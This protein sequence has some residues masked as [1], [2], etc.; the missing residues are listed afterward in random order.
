MVDQKN[1][2][3][4]KRSKKNVIKINILNMLLVIIAVLND[5]DNLLCLS[6]YPLIRIKKRSGKKSK[7]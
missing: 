3:Y 5:N 7:E 2:Y 6:L 4:V 1:I